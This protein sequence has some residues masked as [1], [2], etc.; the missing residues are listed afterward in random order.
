M[1]FFLVL[2]FLFGVIL[3][4]IYMMVRIPPSPFVGGYKYSVT[5]APYATLMIN[6]AK[7]KL[8]VELFEQIIA[9]IRNDDLKNS[10]VEKAKALLGEEL[11]QELLIRGAFLYVNRDKKIGFPKPSK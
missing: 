4:F 7:S 8:G 10:R 5:S 1:N 6:E 2:T 3:F 11:Y 9:D